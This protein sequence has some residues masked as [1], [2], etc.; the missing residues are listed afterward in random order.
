MTS[1]FTEKAPENSAFDDSLR[2]K[3]LSNYI[4]SSIA[5]DKLNSSR[6]FDG[7]IPACV[8]KQRAEDIFELVGLFLHTFNI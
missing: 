4:A 8:H 2:G 7:C 6:I 5:M 3:M 1:Q